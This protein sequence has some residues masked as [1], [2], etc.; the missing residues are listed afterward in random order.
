MNELPLAKG[1]F[2]DDEFIPIGPLT[3]LGMLLAAP[4]AP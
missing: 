1:K 4:S 2:V 3:P